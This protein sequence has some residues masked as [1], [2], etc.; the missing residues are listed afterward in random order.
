MTFRKLI[1][2]K[3]FG[4]N[5]FHTLQGT[6]YHRPAPIEQFLRFQNHCNL[7]V[8]NPGSGTQG[9]GKLTREKNLK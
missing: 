8:K 3:K 1:R 9:Q 2:K 7:I 4:K 6:M 5:D